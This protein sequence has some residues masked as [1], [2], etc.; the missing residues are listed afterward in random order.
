MSIDPEDNEALTPNHFLLG[1]SSGEIRLGKYDRE[2]ICPKGQWKIAQYFA[3]A[4]WQR[5]LKEYLPGLIPRA[6]WCNT[7]KSLKQG[8]VVL[9]AD[10]QTPRNSWRVGE[11]VE[12]YPGSNKVVRIARVRTVHG[13]F[14]RPTRKLIKLSSDEDADS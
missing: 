7:E 9:I 1:T 10:Q 12:I 5:W 8:D 11:I 6:K 4:F 2:A 14:V 13:E 3:D